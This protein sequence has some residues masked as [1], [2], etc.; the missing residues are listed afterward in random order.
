MWWW[1]LALLVVV[2]AAGI[3]GLVVYGPPSDN[4]PDTYTLY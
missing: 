3:A 4:D 1:V 2:I